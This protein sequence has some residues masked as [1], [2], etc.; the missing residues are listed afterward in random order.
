MG[1]PQR[2]GVSSSPGRKLWQATH[3][4]PVVRQFLTM[5]G[6]GIYHYA[7][8]A[9]VTPQRAA[10]ATYDVRPKVTNIMMGDL[11]RIWVY[12]ARGFSAPQQIPDDVKLTFHRLVELGFTEHLN[13]RRLS[14]A[15]TVKTRVSL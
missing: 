3:S 13:W 11:Q 10:R 6:S 7:N 4:V 2:H 5:N 14:S 9:A 12:A 15:L 8:K 1:L